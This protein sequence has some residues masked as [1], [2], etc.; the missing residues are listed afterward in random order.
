MDERTPLIAGNW[1]MHKGRGEAFDYA[2]SSPARSAALDEVDIAVC[3]P[4]TAID[5]VAD[6]L[7]PLGVGIWGQTMHEAEQGAYTGEVSAAMLA[8]AGANGVLLGPL[9]AP[10][11]VR[12]DG[13]GARA[14]AAR[15]HS[16]RV[17]TRPV[18]RRDRAGARRGRHL[19]AAAQSQLAGALDELDACTRPAA[20]DRLRAGLGD[21]HRPHRVARAGAGGARRAARLARRALRAG[22]RGDRA[23]PVRRLRQARERARAVRR[24]R[25]RRRAR[26]RR[27]PLGR[28]P[29]RDRARGAA[30]VDDARR[31]SRSSSW[32]GSGSRRPGRATPS[33]SRTCRSSTALWETMPHTTARR[34]GRSTSGCP[35][36]RWATPRSATSTSA[37]GRIVPQT[38][39]RIGDAVADGCLASQPGLRRRLRRGA[40]GPGRPAPRRPRLRW[41]R[42]LARR[43]PARARARGDGAQ[44]AARR[45][46]RVHGRA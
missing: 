41:R 40:G 5:V 20:D 3:P 35:T 17:S 4:F 44:R 45:R 12:R 19:R 10:R 6:M 34:L 22:R 9:R 24:R 27:E 28:E 39:V 31:P 36:G 1:K 13:R 43:P 14:Q 30:G 32:T 42:A 11:A 8:D 18:R 16:R 23:H 33:R 29:A 38:L 15:R 7:G 21:R 26:R 37:P 25:R 46:A 2:R